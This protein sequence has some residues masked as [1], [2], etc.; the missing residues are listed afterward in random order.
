VAAR[1]FEVN[2]LSSPCL[3]VSAI[4]HAKIESFIGD[5]WQPFYDVTP[6]LFGEF[7]ADTFVDVRHRLHRIGFERR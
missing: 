4:E 3:D 5:F 7:L 2:F 6:S 1:G